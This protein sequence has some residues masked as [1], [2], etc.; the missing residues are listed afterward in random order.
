MMSF[1]NCGHLD[2]KENY[3]IILHVYVFKENK[4]LQ[5]NGKMMMFIL[6]GHFI[7]PYHIYIVLYLFNGNYRLCLPPKSFQCYIE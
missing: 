2:Q 5:K 7:V 6:G 1:L 4:E 3:T